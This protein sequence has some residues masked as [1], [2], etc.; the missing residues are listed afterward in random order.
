MFFTT[1]RFLRWMIFTMMVGNK[2]ENRVKHLLN[3]TIK[4]NVD[5]NVLM[6]MHFISTK[7][8][9]NYMWRK[10]YNLET[11]SFPLSEN[12]K[13]SFSIK[14]Y[15][16]QMAIKNLPIISN[17][18]VRCS[19]PEAFIAP[20]TVPTTEQHIPTNAIMTMNHRMETV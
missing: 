10:S 18:T 5:N 13:S 14:V 17:E 9:F 16:V 7:Y 6:Q 19:L 20:R 4:S 8:F 11:N 15:F 1:I 2:Y 3:N 12:E